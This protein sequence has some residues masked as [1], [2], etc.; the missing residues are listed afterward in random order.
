MS[1]LLFAGAD[2]TCQDAKWT[3][4]SVNH[5]MRNA[6]KM[7]LVTLCKGITCACLDI[8]CKCADVRREAITLEV[9][10]RSVN[11][12]SNLPKIGSSLH[13]ARLSVPG[14]KA[15]IAQRPALFQVLK[16]FCPRAAL[17]SCTTMHQ[18]CA[19]LLWQPAGWQIT[20]LDY[21]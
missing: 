18:S 2:Y 3:T 7:V 1:F 11:Q 13:Q 4:E 5:T 12:T 9:L 15:W 20:S 8:L 6:Q 14:L 19:G 17:Q 10:R 21:D 16:L